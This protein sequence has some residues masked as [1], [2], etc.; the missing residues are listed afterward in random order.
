MSTL[1]PG[2]DPYLED[3]R[4]WAGVHSRFIVYLADQLQP[5]IRPRYIA[6]VEERVFV[7]GPEQRE[8]IPDT[9]L[10]R[11]RPEA[12]PAASAAVLDVDTPVVMQVPELEIHERF[13]CRYSRSRVGTA[14]RDRGGIA[15]SHQQVP[16]R[17]A[18]VVSCQA[19]G[20]SRP[21]DASRRNRSVTCGTARS[22]S[23][24][25]GGAR[26][27]AVPLPD[28]RQPCRGAARSLRVVPMSAASAL[29]AYPR[30]VGR[31]RSRCDAGR[32]IDTG[33]NV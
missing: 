25:V 14:R 17:G 13:V 10:K 3:P 2:M 30:T 6:A 29:T 5:L 23:A 1:F 31:R 28:L 12:P 32:A 4:I 21:L 16:R 27:W 26:K 9:W 24:G 11:H 22:G 19:T 15:Q 7:Q 8:I 20:G 18:G 33:A